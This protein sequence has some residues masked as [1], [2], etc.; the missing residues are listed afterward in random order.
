MPQQRDGTSCGIM[1]FK[2][3]EHLSAGISVDKVDPLKIKYYLLKLAI[4]GYTSTILRKNGKLSELIGELQ[5]LFNGTGEQS[6]GLTSLIMP[7]A[8]LGALGY[9]YMWWKGLKF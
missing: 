7:T 8:T 5:P 9:D 4:E 6:E 3:I 2:F 1:T